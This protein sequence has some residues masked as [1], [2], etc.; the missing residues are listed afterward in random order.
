ML[1]IN[2]QA[3]LK[4]DRRTDG[5]VFVHS[6]FPTIQGEG[7]FAGHKAFFVR[8]TGCNLQ[9]PGCDTEYTSAANLHSPNEVVQRIV[10][11]GGDTDMFNSDQRRQLVVITGGEPF[12]QNINLLCRYLIEIGFI[13]QIETNGVLFPGEGFPWSHKRMIVVCSPKT[14]RIHPDTAKRVSAY[15]YVL[16]A[17]DVAPDGLPIHALQHDLGR[18]LTV[19][20]TPEGWDGPIYVQPMD[21][22]DAQANA[23]NIAACVESVMNHPRYILGVQMHKLSGLP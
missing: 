7:P 15:K 19:A 12:R 23:S 10:T 2:Q 16:E 13:V 11:I 8:L 1:Q 20:R 22:K 17:G 9:C 4:L 14:G 5:K 21:E 18:F 6:I 3:P